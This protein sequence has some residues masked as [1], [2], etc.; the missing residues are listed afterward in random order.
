MHVYSRSVSFCAFLLISSLLNLSGPP[1]AKCAS[2]AWAA[3]QAS[4]AS[5]PIT[6]AKKCRDGAK[7]A[8]RKAEEA[9][10]DAA[11]RAAA[12]EIAAAQARSYGSA[13]DA[14]ADLV[15]T[16]RAQVSTV[17]EAASQSPSADVVA[18]RKRLRGHLLDADWELAKATEATA[19]AEVL[20]S[21]A[22]EVAEAAR[23]ALAKA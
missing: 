14:I 1:G 17:V 10:N 11:V 5:D 22:A 20:G 16:Y 18:G 13:S 15:N 9:A 8:A 21:Q 3:D 19:R 12:S 6:E 2:D 23:G 7:A 4:A